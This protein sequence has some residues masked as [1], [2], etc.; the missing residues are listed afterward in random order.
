MPINEK[1]QVNERLAAYLRRPRE[2]GRFIFYTPSRVTLDGEELPI[3]EC[4]M[5]ALWFL[6]KRE[7]V[8]FDLLYDSIWHVEIP[9]IEQ[10][11][12][13]A[14]MNHLIEVVNS[15]GKGNARI[16]HDPEKGYALRQDMKTVI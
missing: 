9:V 11:E 2:Y 7:S 6:A 8:S 13:I 1:E 3:S 14:R 15:M 10:D 5:D 16:D 12:A 4:Q